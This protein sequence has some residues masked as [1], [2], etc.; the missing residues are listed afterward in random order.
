MMRTHRTIAVSLAAVVLSGGAVAGAA[1]AATA[2]GSAPS[3]CRPANHIARITPAPGSAGHRHYRV[4]LTAPRGYASCRLAGSPS[5]VRFTEHGA[6]V[7]VSAGR[8]G[9]QRTVVTFGPGHPVHFDIQVPDGRRARPADRA[10]FTLR[11]PGGVI[12]GTS[13]A[14]GRLKVAAGT[15][16][17]PVVRGA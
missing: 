14:T 4:T 16:V 13:V 11:A 10:S 8:Y 2:A 9:D 12:P 7:G 6:R 1:Q 17:G 3:A 5:D 15:V